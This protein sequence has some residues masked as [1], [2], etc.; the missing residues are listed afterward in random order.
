MVSKEVEQKV[1]LGGNIWFGDD[2][3]HITT[4][5]LDFY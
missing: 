1:R 4:G 3:D 2:F 5:A